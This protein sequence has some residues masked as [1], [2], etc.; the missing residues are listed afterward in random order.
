MTQLQQIGMDELLIGN[1][2]AMHSRQ[3]FLQQSDE[4]F[5][6]DLWP[7]QFQIKC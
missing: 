1:M 6:E 5:G 3:Y 4:Q 7:G 2:L